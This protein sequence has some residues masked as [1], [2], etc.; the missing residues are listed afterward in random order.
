MQRV[1]HVALL[2]SMSAVT[3]FALQQR[4]T[5]RRAARAPAS[6]AVTKASAPPSVHH[7]EL[8]IAGSFSHNGLFEQALAIYSRLLEASLAETPRR[9]AHLS[10]LYDLR[11]GI[12]ETLRQFDLVIADTTAALQFDPSSS[13]MYLRRGIA[14]AQRH[15]YT[16]AL[17]DILAALQYARSPDDTRDMEEMLRALEQEAIYYEARD[18]LQNR[19]RCRPLPDDYEIQA[20]FD[21]FHSR[22][23][24]PG[25][26]E[27]RQRL[28]YDRH[29]STS[30]ELLY[31]ALEHRLAGR[32]V[33]GYRDLHQALEGL[34]LTHAVAPLGALE[35]GCYLH[36]LGR[37]DAAATYF[38]RAAALVPHSPWIC[39]HQVHNA[40]IRGDGLHAMAELTLAP[41]TTSPT[42]AYLRGLHCDRVTG[43]ET[44]A[45]AHWTRA[46]SLAPEYVAPYYAASQL[47]LRRQAPAAHSILHQCLAWYYLYCAQTPSL[48][49]IHHALGTYEARC[50]RQATA[51]QCFETSLG[52]A[53]AFVPAYVALAELAPEFE[54]AQAYLMQALVHSRQAAPALLLAQLRAEHGRWGHAV[55]ACDHALQFAWDYRD[56]CH[57][58]AVR[59]LASAKALSAR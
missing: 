58:F 32:F 5:Q 49:W 47:Y 50:G 8:S 46:I 13:D 21:S 2:A 29:K 55:D 45:V 23:L 38:D 59:N 52:V 36:V 30:L 10:H 17:H 28:A 24:D 37:Y 20:Y 56:L 19:P 25:V 15:E 54:R 12:Y 6:A 39:A 42:F 51:R 40:I 26:L 11:S 48:G 27:L 22:D 44:S 1:W 4:R 34:D 31:T 33:E 7:M 35:H 3:L 9:R 14:R 57:V 18:A 53:P 41:S 16:L 43:D